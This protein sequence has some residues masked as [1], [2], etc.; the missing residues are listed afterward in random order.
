MY[1][2]GC[3]DTLL[4]FNEDIKFCGFSK[5]ADKVLKPGE[6]AHRLKND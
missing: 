5:I 6:H 1:A 2:I 4:L 3:K